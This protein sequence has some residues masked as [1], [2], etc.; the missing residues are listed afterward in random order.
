MD[1]D[2]CGMVAPSYADP[3]FLLG[4]VHYTAQGTGPQPSCWHED[5]EIKLIRT[6]QTTV[7]IDSDIITAKEDEI[8]FV[9]PY[10]IHSMPKIEGND[11]LYDLFMIHPDFFQSSGIQSLNLRKVFN[12]SRCRIRNHIRNPRLSGILKQILAANEEKGPYSVPLIQGLLM[13]FFSVLLT[14]EVSDTLAEE[15]DPK[16]LRYYRAIE[17][18]V[19]A[20]HARDNEKFSGD[21]LAE[22]CYMRASYFSRIFKRVMGVTPVQYQTEYR[23]RIADLL[24]KYD[25]NSIS[26][27]AHMVGFEDEAYFSRCYKQYKGISPNAFKK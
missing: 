25:S 18:A 17:P 21:E 2:I 16:H 27:I 4:I 9:N 26:A 12:Q 7:I 15:I 5:L 3:S 8:L 11:M 6:G 19:E 14:E 22:M 13:E 23:I 1:M 10:Q 20:I 24:L